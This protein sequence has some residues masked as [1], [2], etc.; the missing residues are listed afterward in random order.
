MSGSPSTPGSIESTSVNHQLA[1]SGPLAW[2]VSRLRTLSDAEQFSLRYMPLGESSHWALG[3]GAI[4]HRSR[5]FFSVIG[6]RAEDQ[7]GTLIEQPLLDQREIGTLGLFLRKNHGFTEALVQLK[8]EPGNVGLF[9][10]APSYQATASNTD[11]VHG[12]A[13]PLFG[14]WLGGDSEFASDT[15]QSEQGT[16]FF[17][18]RNRNV[19]LLIKDSDR[20]TSPFHTWIPIR[21]LCGLLSENHLVNTDLRSTLVCADW[22][23]LAGGGVPF[24]GEGFAQSLRASYELPDQ[25][26]MTSLAE[27]RRKISRSA[28]W[29]KASEIVPLS[30][31][32]RWG[33]GG[34]GP[35]PLG[36]TERPFRMRHIQVQSASREV[37]SWDQ[38]ILQS[39][40]KGQVVL[41]LGYM[42]DIPYLLFKQVAELGFE[43]R[44]E[45][46]SAVLEEP[47]S[48]EQSDLF[49]QS[50]IAAGRAIVSCRQSEE[51]GRFLF[52]ENE[53]A[54]VDIGQAI[55]PPDGYHWL[56]MAQIYALIRQGG[57]F[58]NEARSA[59]SLLL[60]WL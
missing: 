41:P 43:G 31:L 12:G 28:A 44:I 23:M 51:G 52:D 2:L 26:A 20:E 33:M 9:Q 15:L 30:A 3:E 16:R 58:T 39:G 24:E 40:G 45:L 29:K 10:L 19:S 13:S 25:H 11:R 55:K 38:P 53:Y 22:Q 1:N 17:G 54:I 37:R 32:S 5:R 34:E 49:G 35:F 27:V 47:G 60:R 8:A 46:T 48:P 21:Q 59:L 57:V 50:L 56:S 4:R 36:D 6:V 42:S 18:K 14:D 7:N